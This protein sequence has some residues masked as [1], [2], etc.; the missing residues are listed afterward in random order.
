MVFLASPL[1]E[2]MISMYLT[3][4]VSLVKYHFQFYSLLLNLGRG[5]YFELVTLSGLR[6]PSPD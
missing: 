2:R 5:R 4:V 1:K 6:I 3:W